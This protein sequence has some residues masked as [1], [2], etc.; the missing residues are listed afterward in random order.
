MSP[1][2]AGG[3]GVRRSLLPLPQKQPLEQLSLPSR[4]VWEKGVLHMT[5]S[6]QSEV[7]SGAVHGP[8]MTHRAQFGARH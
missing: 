1:D 7:L 3:R 8:F 4:T 6:V 5:P 2:G